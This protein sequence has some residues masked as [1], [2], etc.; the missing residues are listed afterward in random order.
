MIHLD[1]H[2]SM[3][4]FIRR[5]QMQVDTVRAWKDPMY[6]NGL[7]TEELAA[8]SP[9]PAGAIEFGRTGTEGHCEED[10]D[11]LLTFESVFVICITLDQC[12][13]Q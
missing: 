3:Q 7:T 4:T 5:K 1:L 12:V 2:T 6:R 10:G 11:D 8:L 13:M 9:H